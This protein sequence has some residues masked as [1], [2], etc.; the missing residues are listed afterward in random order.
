[1]NKPKSTLSKLKKIY[2]GNPAMVW[3]VV[4][5][6]LI[7]SLGSLNMLNFLYSSPTFFDQF[8][9]LSWQFALLYIGATSLLMGMALLPTTFLAILSGFL[10]SWV[11]LPFLILG[12]TLATII[13]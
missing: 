12:Y 4:W 9:F 10:F 3:T 8:H 11:S 1:M 7:P 13:G 2:D 6:S 5:V